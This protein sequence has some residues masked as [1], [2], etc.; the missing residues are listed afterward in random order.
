M[1][2]V[3]LLSIALCLSGFVF[4]QQVI[5]SA[6]AGVE[7]GAGIGGGK[8]IEVKELG[9]ALSTDSIFTGI[10]SGKVTEVCVKKG[11]FMKI[12]RLDGA[13]PIMVRFKDYGFFVPEDIVGKTVLLDGVAKVKETSVA[14]LKHFAEDAGKSEVEIAKI[15]SPKTDIEIIA[16]GVKIVK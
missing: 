14:Q 4:S 2:R 10:I 13:E 8:K 3:I 15:T 5:P 9:L 6:K 7:Y 11:C 1:K 16:S 12:E